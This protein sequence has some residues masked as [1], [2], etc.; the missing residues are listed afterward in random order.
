M[1]TAYDKFIQ[2][3]LKYGFSLFGTAKTGQT[4][5]YTDG[6]DGENQ[7]GY[8]KTPPR[9]VDNGD[10]TITDKASGLMWIKD[11][12]E[13]GG[14]WGN[15]EEPAAVNWGQAVQNIG[16]VPYA[17][18]SDWRCANLKELLSIMD[19]GK[20]SPSI[21][22]TFFP[23]NTSDYYWTSTTYWDDTSYAWIVDT[24]DG[25]VVT[26]DQ[27]NSWYVMLVRLGVPKT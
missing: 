6:D 21:D 10:G 7:K 14:I 25:S 17:G 13:L 19:Y 5:S 22:E 24:N 12:G 26:D 27:I 9:F 1:L 8:P 18:H 23:F 20:S 3:A 16:G 15:P 11:P 4:I 2:Q